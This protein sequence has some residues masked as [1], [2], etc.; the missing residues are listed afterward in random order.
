MNTHELNIVPFNAEMLEEAASLLAERHQRDRLHS[1]QLPTKYER[2]GNALVA[3]EA[4]WGFARG[5]RIK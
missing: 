3:L 1:P 2:P 5:V 4:I